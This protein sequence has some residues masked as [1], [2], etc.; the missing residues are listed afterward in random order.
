VVRLHR[1]VELPAPDG[2]PDEQQDDDADPRRDEREAEVD[3]R[4]DAGTA[5]PKMPWAVEL[6]P[7][8]EARATSM[9]SAGEATAKAVPSTSPNRMTNATLG[10]SAYSTPAMPI[11]AM[12]T[13]SPRNPPSWS[14]YRPIT[15]E[16][17]RIG[18]PKVRNVNPIRPMLAP[19]EVRYRL[20]T[21]S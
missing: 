14:M 8:G 9:N 13:A 4:E 12:P 15:G 2:E 7:T 17:R 19:S 21:T 18:R 1:V 10:T 5:A 20:H 3:R 16:S 6:R 11:T